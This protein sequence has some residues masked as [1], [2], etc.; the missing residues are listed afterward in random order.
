MKGGI[1]GFA[2]SKGR[3]ENS[4]DEKVT[5]DGQ[6]VDLFKSEGVWVD[7]KI[8]WWS[9]IKVFQSAN[10][11]EDQREGMS[12]EESAELDDDEVKRIAHLPDEE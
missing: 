9:V 6:Y 11:N 10:I 1:T 4:W 7:I 2:H 5:F 3:N 8:L 12:A